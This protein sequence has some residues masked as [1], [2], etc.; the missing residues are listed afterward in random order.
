MFDCAWLLEYIVRCC[1]LAGTV[2]ASI[3]S[4]VGDGGQVW[5]HSVKCLVSLQNNYRV[6]VT[7]YRVAARDDGAIF[8]MDADFSESNARATA[9][10]GP[11]TTLCVGGVWR[12][13]CGGFLT[14]DC[15]LAVVL[16]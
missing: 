5:T 4:K 7:F 6:K 8:T 3:K 14:K 2:R 11:K 12:W 1:A 10:V 13:C 9:G 16:L 15:V